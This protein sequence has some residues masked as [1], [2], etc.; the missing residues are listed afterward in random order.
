MADN[1]ERRHVPNGNWKSN[2]LSGLGLGPKPVIIT[3]ADTG[4]SGL[5]EQAKKPMSADEAYCM[6]CRKRKTFM[7]LTNRIT[8]NGARH[9]RGRCL[10]GHKV[11]KFMSQADYR[12]IIDEMNNVSG[13]VR[14][15]RAG[16]LPGTNRSESRSGPR[17]PRQGDV[18]ESTVR[19]DGR[20]KVNGQIL[21]IR[22]DRPI[23]PGDRVR[24]HLVGSFVRAIATAAA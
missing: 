16:D 3:P 20:V 14:S 10:L 11:S 9:I 13:R 8:P 7:P 18:V 12:A 1:S 17:V 15:K 4:A 23:R 2:L 6:T 24:G 5:A 21:E 22:S 19:K